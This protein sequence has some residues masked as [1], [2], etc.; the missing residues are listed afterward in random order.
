MLA[1]I[2]LVPIVGLIYGTVYYRKESQR[3][4][5]EIGCLKANN[6]YL[7]AENASITDG[8][9]AALNKIDKLEDEYVFN[10]S[11]ITEHDPSLLV[12]D[13]PTT[14]SY[15]QGKSCNCSTEPEYIEDFVSDVSDAIDSIQWTSQ[16]GE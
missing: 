8:F 5:N 7:I 12:S 9:T 15:W 14:D 11:D 4:S 2:L 16:D 3:L 6:K 1:A 13:D 10:D